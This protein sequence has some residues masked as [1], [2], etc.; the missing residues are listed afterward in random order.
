MHLLGDG[1][2]KDP[3]TAEASSMP[4]NQSDVPAAGPA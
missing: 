1:A 4:K 3:P 2:M